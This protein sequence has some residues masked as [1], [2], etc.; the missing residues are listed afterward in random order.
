MSST[1]RAEARWVVVQWP[2]CG[3]ETGNDT[4]S[5]LGIM[6]GRFTDRFG[7]ATFSN[8]LL[9]RPLPPP[10]AP[11][12]RPPAPQVEVSVLQPAGVS[13]VPEPCL[14]RKSGQLSRHPASAWFS[15]CSTDR[16]RGSFV[17]AVCGTAMALFYMRAPA[18]RRSTRPLCGC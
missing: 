10:T 3:F 8:L 16:T 17:C 1:I 9:V 13:P 12:L 15:R 11:L 18:C 4:H 5:L 7:E 6:S 14:V 2:R